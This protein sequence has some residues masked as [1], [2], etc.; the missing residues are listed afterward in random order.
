MKVKSKI[1]QNIREG[2]SLAHTHHNKGAARIW[3]TS[4]QRAAQP[5]PEHPLLMQGRVPLLL[6]VSPGCQIRDPSIRLSPHRPPSA[7]K[8]SPGSQVTRLQNPP[9]PA[10]RTPKLPVLA[11]PKGPECRAKRFGGRFGPPASL[12]AGFPSSRSEPEPRAQAGG[13]PTCVLSALL[14]RG[15]RLHPGRSP[16]THL[17]ARSPF[18]GAL[19]H[20]PPLLYCLGRFTARDPEDPT[21][22]QRCNSALLCALPG[23]PLA[24][25]FVPPCPL[26][27]IIPASTSSIQLCT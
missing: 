14:Q 1:L 20:R 18:R 15:L 10:P 5:S 27:S 25:I 2:W 16:V 11:L 23:K 24:P 26:G 4:L 9:A 19:A 7:H 13:S 21:S 12:G 3:H 17:S 8:S 22:S 6:Q